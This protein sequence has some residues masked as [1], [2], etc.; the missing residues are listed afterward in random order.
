MKEFNIRRTLIVEGI[1]KLN[2]ISCTQPKG[3]FYAFPNIS[4]TGMTSK[5][6]ADK[7]LYECGVAL[8]PGTAFGEFG[9]GYVRI[10]FANSSKNLNEAISRLSTILN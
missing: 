10:S 8:L 9:E 7:A 6:F 2:G 4:K 1:N 3:A 5:E